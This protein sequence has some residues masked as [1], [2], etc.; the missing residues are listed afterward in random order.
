M[1]YR[2]KVTWIAVGLSFPLI[3]IW[4]Y[5]EIKAMSSIYKQDFG[6]GVIIYADEYVR[7]G[8]WVFDCKNS[9]LI[10]RIPL[11]VP[12]AELESAKKFTTGNLFYLKDTDKQPAKD[13]LKEITETRDWY[14]NLRHLYSALDEDSNLNS[15]MFYMITS[16]AGRKWAVE[17]DQLIDYV[18]SSRFK[19]YATPYDVETYVDYA[20][21]LKAAANSCPKPQ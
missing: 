12:L 5:H 9:R 17:V 4:G 21:A 1:K 8:D 6:N 11:P 18:G 10:S 7:T 13:A 20:K 15:H 3:L 2:S 19:I 14:K 16:Y